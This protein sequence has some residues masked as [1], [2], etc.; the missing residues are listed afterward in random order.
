MSTPEEFYSKFEHSCVSCLKPLEAEQAQCDECEY[1]NL[2]TDSLK[3]R[4][5]IMYTIW[6]RKQKIQLSTLLDQYEGGGGNLVINIDWGELKKIDIDLDDVDFLVTYISANNRTLQMSRASMGISDDEVLEE[7]DAKEHLEIFDKAFVE[8]LW[9]GLLKNFSSYDFF[10]YEFDLLKDFLFL[11]DLIFKTM[12]MERLRCLFR[13]V[14]FSETRQSLESFKKTEFLE[15]EDIGSS[16][17]SDAERLIRLCRYAHS[18]KARLLS[19][20]ILEI[21]HFAGYDWEGSEILQIAPLSESGSW[22]IDSY[23]SSI[24]LESLVQL[25]S[26]KTF[27]PFKEPSKLLPLRSK[28]NIQMIAESLR[29]LAGKIEGLDPWI[30]LSCEEVGIKSPAAAPTADLGE[31]YVVSRALALNGIDQT[32]LKSWVDKEKFHYLSWLVKDELVTPET[33]FPVLNKNKLNKTDFDLFRLQATSTMSQLISLKDVSFSPSTNQRILHHFFSDPN[34]NESLFSRHSDLMPSFKRRVRSLVSHTVKSE[35][36]LE[37]AVP[38]Y[39]GHSP[40]FWGRRNMHLTVDL[41]KEIKKGKDN[42]LTSFLRPKIQRDKK[43]K[44]KHLKF[45]TLIVDQDIFS[46]LFKLEENDEIAHYVIFEFIEGLLE[47]SVINGD[48][49]L[50]SLV[51][52]AGFDYFCLLKSDAH[53]F[54]KSFYD[55]IKESEQY[56][57][58]FFTR[59]QEN[60]E[61]SLI[62]VSKLL[63][64]MHSQYLEGRKKVI[65]RI[66]SSV[67]GAG[68]E[69]V[70]S[71]PTFVASVERLF[72]HE[73]KE[74]FVELLGEFLPKSSESQTEVGAVESPQKN[75]EQIPEIVESQP[76]GISEKE[77]E[78]SLKNQKRTIVASLDEELQEYQEVFQAASIRNIQTVTE[79]ITAMIAEHTSS[80]EVLV[81]IQELM[82]LI[83]EDLNEGVQENMEAF[84]TFRK[85][86]REKVDTLGES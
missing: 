57:N 67:R 75:V 84:V 14:T 48:E 65:A 26:Y 70:E 59:A 69:R 16:E 13:F 27:Q 52:Q 44:D 42:S 33:K 50:K 11:P 51:A 8:P 74:H 80:P 32:Q 23:R 83:L 54:E 9:D 46:Y 63:N 4:L 49:S 3:T 79:R 34:P 78:Q 39:E 6:L 40:E 73:Y 1:S 28:I 15:L 5:A 10:D 20:R 29:G 17:T 35:A 85:N 45:S 30:N 37:T 72:Q 38:L 71:Y 56:E 81:A 77:V 2:K 68:L 22:L 24:F 82:T 62:F 7:D 36:Y 76:Q 55:P 41:I 86:L 31:D 47:F 12:N 19:Q 18:D 66:L 25:L 64:S 21:G 58:L 60:P 53:R 43:T 61:K